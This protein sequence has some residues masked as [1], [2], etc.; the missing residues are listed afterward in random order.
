[1]HIAYT[2]RHYAFRGVP[3][4]R[5]KISDFV[6]SAHDHIPSICAQFKNKRP[7]KYL[8]DSFMKRNN[9][10]GAKPNRQEAERYHCTN[11]DVLTSLISNLSE[12]IRRSDIDATRLFNLYETGMSPGIGCHGVTRK[13]GVVPRGYRCHT[14]IVDF[15]TNLSRAS[16]LW[17]VC[18]AG[19]IISPLWIFNWKGLLYRVR[20]LSNGLLAT[21]SAASILSPDSLVGTRPEIGGIDTKILTSWCKEFLKRVN[22]LTVGPEKILLV[23]DALRAHMS[24]SCL[25]I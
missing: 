18:A 15:A 9:L 14:K 22:C 10:K 23:Y 20:R 21:D 6:F 24:L 12:L 3:L 11:A 19:E 16:L 5:E 7:G 4:V 2:C 8:V 1:M 13:K 25:E 17:C